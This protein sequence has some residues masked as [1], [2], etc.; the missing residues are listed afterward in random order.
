MLGWCNLVKIASNWPKSDYCF[1]RISYDIFL[2]YHYGGTIVH[3]V[4]SGIT[5]NDG[6]NLLING[7]LGMSYTE[8]KETICYGFG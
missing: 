8:M 6:S 1:Y 2:L 7:N 5:Y 3:D 4:N